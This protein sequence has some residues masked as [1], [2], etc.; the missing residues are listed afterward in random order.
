MII[1]DVETSGLDPKT[2]S[3]LSIGAVEFENPTNQFYG[4][5]ALFEG[6]MIDEGSLAVNGFSHQA[7]TDSNKWT[8]RTLLEKFQEW[9]GTIEDQTLAGM[10]TSFDHGFLQQSTLRCSLK[11]DLG[12]RSLDLYTVAYLHQLRRGIEPPLKAHLSALNSDTIQMYVGLPSEPRP[13]KALMGAKI[14]A[15]AFNRLLFGKNLLE[16]F[17]QYPLPE[18]LETKTR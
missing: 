14:E 3:L 6:A 8:V 12:H 9:V 2:A 7:I 18:Y 1:V 4:E 15:E 10:N 5:C 16:E 17:Q 11:W 13:H